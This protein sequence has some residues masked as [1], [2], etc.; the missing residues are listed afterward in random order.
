MKKILIVEDNALNMDLLIQLLE[1][2][3]YEVITAINGSEGWRLALEAKPDLILMD[4]KLPVMNGWETT[5]KIKE[6]EL[7]KHIPVIGI[8]SHAM[9]S[10]AEKA[11]AIGCDDYLTKPLDDML[12]FEKLKQHLGE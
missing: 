3:Q 1:E 9:S 7:T 4:M 5:R 6:H 10:D 11:F 12:L 2:Q 8:S